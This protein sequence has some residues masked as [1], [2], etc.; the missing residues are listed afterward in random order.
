MTAPHSIDPARFLAE[1]L[2]DPGSD[3]LRAMSTAFVNALMSVEADAICGAEHGVS[4]TPPPAATPS[5]SHGLDSEAG[6]PIQRGG[7]ITAS[8][9]AG[10][11][12]I[13]DLCLFH[14]KRAKR[15]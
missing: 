14:V 1:Q 10:L 7:H 5:T 15:A 9:D 6:C 13:E 8:G 2:A 12:Y 4:A 3:L 11:L